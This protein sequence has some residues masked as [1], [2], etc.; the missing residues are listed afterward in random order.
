VFLADTVMVMGSRPG[1]ILERVA[2]DLPRPR[3]P[4]VLRSRAFHALCDRFGEMLFRQAEQ[5]EA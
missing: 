5:A 4:E 1:R 2:I 3:R